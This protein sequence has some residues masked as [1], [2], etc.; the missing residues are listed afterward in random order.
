MPHGIV[1]TRLEKQKG[2]EIGTIPMGRLVAEN[3][4]S[5]II[6]KT[7]NNYDDANFDN[8]LPYRDTIDEIIKKHKI[9]Y[10][11]D[12]HGLSR[13]CPFDINLG[14]RIG[15][16]INASPRALEK[17]LRFLAPEF[18]LGLDQPFMATSRTISGHYA[19]KYNIFTLQVEINCG[20]TNT[21]KTIDKF[22]RL[23]Q[24]FSEW[25]NSLD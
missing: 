5:H 24:I 4:D 12:F 22:N 23:V 15:K 14:T 1:Q 20:L 9:K 6:I 16:N 11:I 10:L 2:A 17:L 25:I 3:T 7:K 13:K 8:N 21:Y 19:D 18:T